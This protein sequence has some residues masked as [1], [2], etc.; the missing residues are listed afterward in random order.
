VERRII[1]KPEWVSSLISGRERRRLTENL[2][3]VAIKIRRITDID[4]TSD[5]LL[6]DD[7]LCAL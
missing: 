7:I 2:G 3:L 1:R 6:P 5:T 4:C